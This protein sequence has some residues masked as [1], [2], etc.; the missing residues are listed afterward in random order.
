MEVPRIAVAPSAREFLRQTEQ[1][2]AG[3]LALTIRRPHG[4]RPMSQPEKPPIPGRSP[5]QIEDGGPSE[6]VSHK[7]DIFFAA[8]ET[9]RMPMLVTDPRQA[10]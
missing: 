3:T 10:R 5:V 1:R 7:D 9:T 8:I 6:F 2:P 4:P